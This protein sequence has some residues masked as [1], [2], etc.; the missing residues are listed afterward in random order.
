MNPVSSCLYSKRPQEASK[1]NGLHQNNKKEEGGTIT[2]KVKGKQNKE[3]ER[4]LEQCA[5]ELDGDR[6]EIVQT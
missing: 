4:D 5:F 3:E 1:K 2:G 6:E